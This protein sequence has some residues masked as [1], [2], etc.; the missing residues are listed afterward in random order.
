[1]LDTLRNLDDH[2]ALI[3][4]SSTAHSLLPDPGVA[5]PLTDVLNAPAKSRE[6]LLHELRHKLKLKENDQSPRAKAEIFNKLSSEISKYALKNA[7]IPQI[8]ARL[9][10][11]GDLKPSSY[12]IDI[13]SI[14]RNRLVR[15]GIRPNHIEDAL[16]TPDA[17]H[18]VNSKR[19]NFLV[20]LFLHRAGSGKN[21]F[22]L[23]T[24]ALRKGYTLLVRDA[25]RIYDAAIDIKGANEPLAVLRTF[26]NSYGLP[27]QIGPLSG[28][29]LLDDAFP[30][31]GSEKELPNLTAVNGTPWPHL[32]SMDEW[33]G[34]ST[35]VSRRA[36]PGYSGLIL[37]QMN[38]RLSVV[39]IAIAYAFDERKYDED[40]RRHGVP[41]PQH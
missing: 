30:F 34:D 5:S 11:R 33:D 22:A 19:Q 35:Y 23:F 9:G 41:V 29:L 25:L 15:R 8:K 17:L 36:T 32:G 12:E 4:L 24:V 3:L 14:T 31:I 16:R 2:D 28:L 13:P 21:T 26:L 37:A 18:H 20:S 1:M 10:A 27:V 6:Q 40:L 39:E 7:D 38:P